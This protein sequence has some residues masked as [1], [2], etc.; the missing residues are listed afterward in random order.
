MVVAFILIVT[1]IKASEDQIIRELRASEY[2][3]EVYPV[4]GVYDIIVKVEAKNMAQLKEIIDQHIRVIN[5]IRST[6]TMVEA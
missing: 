3:K 4:Y 6:L 1:E 2:V 5:G